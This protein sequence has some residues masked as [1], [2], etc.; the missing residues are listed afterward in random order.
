MKESYQRPET[1]AFE[2]KPLSVMVSSSI[3]YDHYDNESA[4]SHWIPK[5]LC[6]QCVHYT[7]NGCP[8]IDL[9]TCRFKDKT[10]IN[11]K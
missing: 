3:H 8:L 9:E 5:R 6:K 4:C 2:C 10:P 7:K 11:N 1:S